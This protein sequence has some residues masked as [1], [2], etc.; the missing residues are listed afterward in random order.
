MATSDNAWMRSM[1]FPK[2]ND[3][4]LQ[5]SL[6]K[7]SDKASL[8]D[9]QLNYEQIRAAETVLKSQYGRVPYLIQGPPGTGKTKTVVEIALRL[10]REKESTRL[11][12]CTPSNSASD[13]L[14]RRLSQHFSPGQLL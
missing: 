7:T 2:T 4:V 1:L 10:V 9:P 13:T 5:R 3:G 12:L 14:V 8:C 6:N 11:L